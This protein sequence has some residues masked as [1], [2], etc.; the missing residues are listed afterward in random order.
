ML[1]FFDAWGEQMD[2]WAHRPT[3]GTSWG[4]SCATTAAARRGWRRTARCSRGC[5]GDRGAARVQRCAISPTSCTAPWWRRAGGGRAA[6]RR[7]RLRRRGERA[8]SIR[9]ASANTVWALRR[10][11]SAGRRWLRRRGAACGGRI[12]N[13]AARLRT[14]GHR[15]H[16]VGLRDGGSCGAGALRGGGGGGGR[17]AR[18]FT[19]QG[20]ANTAWAFATADAAPTRF[21]AVAAGR[22]SGLALTDRPSP[23]LRGF[24]TLWPRGSGALRGGGGGGGG[25]AARRSTSKHGVGARRRASGSSSPPSPS[26]SPSRRT[27]RQLQQFSLWCARELRL[28][29]SPT[30]AARAGCRDSVATRSSRRDRDRGTGP[31]HFG[32]SGDGARAEP[33]RQAVI[34]GEHLKALG[35]AAARSTSRSR[36]AD[37]ESR[38]GRGVLCADE[39]RRERLRGAARRCSSGGCWRRSA[40]GPRRAVL[41]VGP[42]RP[43]EGAGQ[44][45]TSLATSR[46]CASTCARGCSVCVLTN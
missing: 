29:E 34:N 10:R 40:G 6:S 44:R 25:A 22:R 2:R 41:G 45:S 26:G 35:R 38:L 33:A 23:T 21:I 14:A 39:R 9:R 8:T 20:I 11:H 30:P 1:R 15:Q 18:D 37:R 43:R 3:S 24:A 4:S 13:R 36:R 17:A 16:G 27:S 31:R 7:W 5:G 19:P 46:R 32:S 42:A 28:P 12:G